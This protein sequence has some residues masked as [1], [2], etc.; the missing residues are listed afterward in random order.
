MAVCEKV[1]GCP[2]FNEKMSNMPATAAGY[3]RKYCM[4]DNQN[5]ARYMVLKKLGG[6]KVPV[7]LF[8]NQVEKAKMLIK[9][10]T[11]VQ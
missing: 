4:G 11:I 9:E 2:F 6:D 5:C 7:D 8:P 1:K 3:K 10:Q